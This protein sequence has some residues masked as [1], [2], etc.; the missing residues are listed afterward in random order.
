MLRLGSRASWYFRVLLPSGASRKQQ[1]QEGTLCSSALNPKQSFFSHSA[2][3]GESLP[4]VLRGE[5]SVQIRV[6]VPDAL[7]HSPRV[8]HEGSGLD[9]LPL[10]LGA[11]LRPQVDERDARH[12]VPVRPSEDSDSRGPAVVGGHDGWG[13]LTRSNGWL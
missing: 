4:E 8:R 9:T 2:G 5:G 10:D 3:T 12:L 7:L 6:H 13:A 11:V 1:Q